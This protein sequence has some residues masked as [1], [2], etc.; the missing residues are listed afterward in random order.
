MLVKWQ[1]EQKWTKAYI[2]TASVDKT[3]KIFETT[4]LWPEWLVPHVL[5]ALNKPTEMFVGTYNDSR[6][7]NKSM[8]SSRS[9][10]RKNGANPE[11]TTIFTYWERQKIAQLVISFI[12]P[13]NNR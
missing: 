8:N 11:K 12:E 6:L 7:N 10:C 4:I 1:V 5:W 2:T 13:C 9:A 3:N